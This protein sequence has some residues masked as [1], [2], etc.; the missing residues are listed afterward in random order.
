MGRLN[1]RIQVDILILV[2]NIKSLLRHS[3]SITRDCFHISTIM[4]MF[5]SPVEVGGRERERDRETERHRYR[6][7]DR[8]TDRQTETDRKP[9]NICSSHKKLFEVWVLERVGRKA[10]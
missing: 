4:F 7:T 5:S 6:Q 9:S 8:Q 1:K 2:K 3:L 10:E